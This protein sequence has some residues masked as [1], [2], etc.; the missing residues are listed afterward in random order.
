MKKILLIYGLIMFAMLAV[1]LSFVTES[2]QNQ[3]SSLMAIL[4]FILH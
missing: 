3:P 2:E 1:S 4:L